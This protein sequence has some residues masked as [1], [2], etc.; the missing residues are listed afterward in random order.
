M[1]EEDDEKENEEVL[2]DESIIMDELEAA[3][4]TPLLESIGPPKILQY[5]PESSKGKMTP[6]IVDSEKTEKT[7]KSDINTY[8]QSFNVN[9]NGNAK[10]EFCGQLT[11]AWP[12]LEDQ[13]RKFP[14][15]VINYSCC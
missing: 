9:I 15:D 11:M 12:S 8:M 6:T 10:C 14:D 5:M 13:E 7:E 4:K 1:I 2:F 3:T